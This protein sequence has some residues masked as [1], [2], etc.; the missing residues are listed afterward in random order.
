MI[1]LTSPAIISFRYHYSRRSPGATISS[2][3]VWVLAVELQTCWESKFCASDD[4][5]FD[6]RTCL[7]WHTSILLH[8][9]RDARPTQVYQIASYLPSNRNSHLCDSWDH[10]ILLLRFIRRLA[11][12]G[13][14]QR[15]YQ[16]GLVRV[17]SPRPPRNNDTCNS[18]KL[19]KKASLLGRCMS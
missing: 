1:Q 13:V 19:S 10:H 2:T 18:R 5:Y 3:T 15:H 17:R 7:L 4:R 16:N 8:H 6:S 9:F 14:S 12:I 11:S